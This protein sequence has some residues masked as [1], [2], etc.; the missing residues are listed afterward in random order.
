MA[1]GRRAQ[2]AD[3]QVCE[4]GGLPDRFF[5]FWPGNWQRLGADLCRFFTGWSRHDV[6]T[7]TGTDMVAEI[8]KANQIAAEQ[9]RE[10]ERA[11][12]RR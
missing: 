11:Q 2:D 6:E 9:K 3:Q 8:E 7:L 12:R 1:K 5:S 10:A 4:S